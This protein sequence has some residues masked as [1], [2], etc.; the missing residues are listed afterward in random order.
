M[1]TR[2]NSKKK[3]VSTE[4]GKNE[5]ISASVDSEVREG[6]Q[7]K[8]KNTFIT[9]KAPISKKETKTRKNTKNAK[10]ASKSTKLVNSKTK[11]SEGGKPITKSPCC[12]VVY[13]TGDYEYFRTE[14]MAR[15]QRSCL[16]ASLVTEY[17]VFP[18]KDEGTEFMNGTYY[19]QDKKPAANPVV[20]IVS[21]SKGSSCFG[22]PNEKFTSLNANQ[23]AQ[24]RA[25]PT[26]VGNPHFGNPHANL[27]IKAL[28]KS[29]LESITFPNQGSS[30]VT[31]A[32]P[33]VAAA[34]E[35]QY[36]AS[37]QNGAAP[38]HNAA[39]S[40]YLASMKS[41][42]TAD[43]VQL[44]VH[45]FKYPFEPVPKYQVVMFELYDMRQ[46]KTYWIHHPDKWEQVFQRD[47]SNSSHLYDDVCY[48]FHS[49]QMR[50]VTTKTSGYQNEPWVH[51]GAA[52]PDGSRY[53][54]QMKGLYALF[55]FEYNLEEIEEDVRVFCTNCL[56]PMAME[57]Y[58]MA[59]YSTND[60][61]RTSLQPG[62]GTY[63]QMLG[64]ALAGNIKIIE[65]D[66]LDTMFL[67]DEVCLFM[68]ILFN[69]TRHPRDYQN[70]NLINYAYGR[71]TA[72][73][74]K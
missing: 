7:K 35:N 60:K 73:D 25:P 33:G 1:E 26:R 18:T 14:G 17:R 74:W 38:V 64:G 71:V 54:I 65:E 16:P 30:G 34:S 43:L 56:K 29:G 59:H 19:E 5:K 11:K 55:P 6:K 53:K 46:N 62:V 42:S 72:N 13:N 22:N 32:P 8:P 36:L 24:F 4:A 67:N 45:I 39:D 37:F 28:N 12:V 3:A 61:V 47:H 48:N 2:C 9:K 58:N 68:R 63:W 41:I 20:R 52:R 21:P 31:A 44:Q 10:C 66:S 69:E 50:D 27:P 57:V 70:A 15:K 23:N 40:A 49:F 51:E